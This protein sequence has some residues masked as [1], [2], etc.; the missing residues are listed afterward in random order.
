MRNISYLLL[1]SVC[2]L[3]LSGCASPREY[4]TPSS[5][6]GVDGTTLTKEYHGEAFQT[7]DPII[8]WWQELNDEQLNTL[9]SKAAHHN[10]DIEIT[11]ANLKEARAF[12]KETQFD[13]IPTVRSSANSTYTRASEE[14]SG[15]LDDRT[16]ELYN[17]RLDASWELD[18][19]G[20]VSA[21]VDAAKARE[22]AAVA[23][24][25]DMRIIIFAEVAS[26]Y[27]QLR[28]LQ[29]R[30]DIAQ[31]NA[32]NQNETYDLSVRLA[33]GGRN[34]QLDVVRAQTQLEL[35]RS[36]IPS[37]E[38]SIRSNINR[39]SVLTGQV[40]DALQEQLSETHA[41]PTVPQVVNV[42]EVK[43]LLRRRPDIQ[44]AE[45]NLEAS[46][47]DYNISVADQFPSVSLIGNLGFAATNLSDFGSS[48]LVSNIGPSISWAAFDFGRV[49]ARIR[50][51]DARAQAALSSYEKTIL[52]ALEDLQ[53]S[54]TNFVKEEERR[55]R[56]QKAARLS[57]EAATL[58]RKRYEAGVDAFIDVLSAEA[59]LLEAEDTLAQS[60]ISAALQLI[61]IY[62]ALGGGWIIP[63]QN[64]DVDNEETITK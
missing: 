13:Y 23:D 18:L 38:A 55:A 43:D 14:T 24:M 37:L 8:S 32:G 4:N 41:L 25:H 15:A 62:K 51:N 9:I 2:V 26:T 44:R 27:I 1:T 3:S 12:R 40:P 10:K 60:E 50:Q 11:V 47:A 54:M 57:K 22:Q 6:D 64:N 42:G 63:T 16:S 52:E 39:L 30:L 33:N 56:L 20:R 31:R 35:T 5:P 34:S 21:G 59:T 36:T 45:R 48:A 58:A 53:T 46:I 17:A 29:Y 61:A 49:K 19:F 28:G 7:K